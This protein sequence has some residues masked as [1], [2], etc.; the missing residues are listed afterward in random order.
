MPYANV[1]VWVLADVN[2]PNA[3][4]RSVDSNGYVTDLNAQCTDDLTDLTA[5][6]GAGCACWG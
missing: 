1:L 5:D 4:K 3:V 6:A 2:Y